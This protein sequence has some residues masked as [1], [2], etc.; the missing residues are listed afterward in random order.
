MGKKVCK[1]NRCER[2]VAA[3]GFFLRNL[4]LFEVSDQA[5]PEDKESLRRFMRF[6]YIPDRNILHGYWKKIFIADGNPSWFWT[7]QRTNES[8]FSTFFPG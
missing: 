6:N 5:T 2:I 1:C 4:E 7:A 3:G 8:L